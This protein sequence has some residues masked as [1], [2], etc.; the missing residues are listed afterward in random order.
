MPILCNFE[1]EKVSQCSSSFIGKQ[2]TIL[3]YVPWPLGHTRH[4]NRCQ[5]IQMGDPNP[6]YYF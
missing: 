5:I 6:I 4:T 3:F 2:H 1:K